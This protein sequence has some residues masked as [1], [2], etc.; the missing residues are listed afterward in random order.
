[1]ESI[2]VVGSWLAFLLWGGNFPGS[3]ILGRLYIA[4]VLLIPGLL[5]ALIGAHLSLVVRQKHTDFPAAGRTEQTVSGERLYPVYGLKSVGFFLILCA[6]LTALGGLAQ[7][8]PVWLWGPYEPAAQTS[9]AQP[10]WYIGF[11]EGSLRLFP[12]I[13]IHLFHHTISPIFWPTVALPVVMFVVA[14]SYPF[15]ERRLSRD[16]ERH[17]LLQRPRD[18]PAR[19]AIG[20]MA[21]TFWMVLNVAW[22]DDIMAKAFHLSMDSVVIFLR[23]ATIVAPPIVF[24]VTYWMCLGLEEHDREVLAEGIETGMLR[25]LPDGDYV[26]AHQPLGPVN[27]H[28]EGVLTYAGAPVPKR[29]NEVLP[30]MTSNG[31]LRPRSKAARHSPLPQNQPD[32]GSARPKRR[33]R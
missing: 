11:L 33:V 32:P 13:E 5:L 12:P 28:D 16:Q 20:A 22:A 10:D 19:T 15:L 8:N 24:F 7:I 21:L 9:G 18:A 17:N 6:T 29:M 25:R 3:E 27:E 23:I 31:F 1:V 14:G 30:P 4:H 26:E 2:P